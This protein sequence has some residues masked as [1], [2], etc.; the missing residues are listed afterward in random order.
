VSG[1][2]LFPVIGC[3]TNQAVKNSGFSFIAY[4]FQPHPPLRV[5]RTVENSTGVGSVI[6]ANVP[7]NCGLACVPAAWFAEVCFFLSSLGVAQIL[8]SNGLNGNNLTFSFILDVTALK[9]SSG[10]E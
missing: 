5:Q 3:G 6:V 9:L 1:W 4:P 10:Y 7:I 2:D 8:N